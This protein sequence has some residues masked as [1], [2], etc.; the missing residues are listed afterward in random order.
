MF[1]L[2]IKE[3]MRSHSTL[4]SLL[5]EVPKSIS[6]IIKLHNDFKNM[7]ID[8]LFDQIQ[9]FMTTTKLDVRSEINLAAL[10]YATGKVC[11]NII[12]RYN[13]HIGIFL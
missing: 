2:S 6:V 9:T 13:H 7:M 4:E 8:P 12:S 10:L 11:M 5:A 3:R 1:K